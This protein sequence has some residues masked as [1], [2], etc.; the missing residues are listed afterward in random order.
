[1]SLAANP[2]HS[3][4]A[5]RC[6]QQM[7]RDGLQLEQLFSEES[8][9]PEERA[10]LLRA[11]LKAKPNFRL[12]QPCPQVSPVELL[13]EVYAKVSRPQW[14]RPPRGLRLSLEGDRR[15]QA[16]CDPGPSVQCQVGATR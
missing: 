2:L 12:P 1:M 9:S 10:A 15:R 6:L 3:L 5:R 7:A 16:G 8:L 11:V 4:P 13:Q 14:L